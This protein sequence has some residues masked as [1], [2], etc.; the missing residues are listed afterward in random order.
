MLFATHKTLHKTELMLHYSLLLKSVQKFDVL[1]SDETK[2]NYEDI[3][4]FGK[5]GVNVMTSSPWNISVTNN[6][7]IIL[8]FENLR[9]K[10]YWSLSTY[11]LRRHIMKYVLTHVEFIRVLFS[12]RRK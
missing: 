2:N 7:I 3:S 10:H 11:I 5:T 9:Y 1:P 4:V 12:E 6:I 8:A